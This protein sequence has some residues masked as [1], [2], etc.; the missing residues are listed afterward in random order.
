MPPV[1]VMSKKHKGGEVASLTYPEKG[2]T[3]NHKIKH[4]GHPNDRPTGETK[5]CILHAPD[6]PQGSVN[7]LKFIRT[8][9]SCISN[10]KI[11]KPT[12]EENLS[13]A[14][15]LSLE[16]THRRSK[17]W[18]PMMILALRKMRDKN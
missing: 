14:N 3:G 16:I 13:M 11:K 2:R 4:S 7:Y 9:M 1:T 6:T 12:P 15:L 5:T 10:I 18:K 17:S 8:S